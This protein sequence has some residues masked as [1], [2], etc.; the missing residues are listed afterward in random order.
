M[1]LLF[2]QIYTCLLGLDEGKQGSFKGLVAYIFLPPHF[3]VEYGVVTVSLPFSFVFMTCP[4]TQDGPL[5]NR[6][7]GAS[8]CFAH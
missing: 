6:A 5:K 8:F 7:L 2:I 3:E 4:R 1:A